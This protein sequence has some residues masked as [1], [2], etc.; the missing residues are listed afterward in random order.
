MLGNVRANKSC[1]TGDENFHKSLELG[2]IFSGGDERLNV[3]DDV[4]FVIRVGHAE[5]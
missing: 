3:G 1:T 4:R 2:G 5:P